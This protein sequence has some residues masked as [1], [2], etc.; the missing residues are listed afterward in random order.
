MSKSG[1]TDSTMDWTLSDREDSSIEQGKNCDFQAWIKEQII[2][3]MQFWFLR[4]I[5]FNI[6]R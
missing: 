4:Q 5:E 2:G 1:P 6:S 3:K